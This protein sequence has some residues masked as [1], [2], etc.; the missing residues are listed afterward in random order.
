[1]AFFTCKCFI[2]VSSYGQGYVDTLKLWCVCLVHM[3]L[4]MFHEFVWPQWVSVGVVK[5]SGACWDRTVCTDS[6][7]SFSLCRRRVVRLHSSSLCIPWRVFCARLPAAAP[8]PYSQGSP[9]C[10]VCGQW[11][12]HVCGSLGPIK[13]LLVL[14]AQVTKPLDYCM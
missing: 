9:S 3:F 1:M 4:C 5:S 7:L 2:N 13:P 11:E 12:H 10:R 14:L 8:A 6:N